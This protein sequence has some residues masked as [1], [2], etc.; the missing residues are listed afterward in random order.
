MASQY[1]QNEGSSKLPN[2]KNNLD[3]SQEDLQ[4]QNARKNVP[5][6]PGELSRPTNIQRIQ[7]KKQQVKALP[8]V[9]KLEKLAVYSSCKV[10]ITIYLSRL[11]S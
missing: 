10:S 5:L 8:K 9:K 4:Q 3:T 11:R 7:Q 6:T 2:N 1:G